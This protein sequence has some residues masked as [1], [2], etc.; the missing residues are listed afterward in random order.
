MPYRDY[1]EFIASL[2][3]HGVK[4]LIVGA[5]AV[6]YHARPRATKDLD[7]L[8][9]ASPD[10]ARR[11]LAS[12]EQF[13]GAKTG[14]AVK[15]LL[16]PE[17][18]IQLGVAPVRIDLLSSIKGCP[19]FAAIWKRRVDARF[20]TVPAYYLGF[21]DL[22]AAKEAAGRLQDRV[23]VRSLRRTKLKPKRPGKAKSK[24]KPSED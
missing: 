13:L 15:D 19:D 4:Y 8:I 2:N 5:H 21:E 10:N 1:E 7:V 14:Y 23:D 9:D 20:G 22:I 6:A 18:I 3:E 11:V 12:L 17:T 16:D 24:N